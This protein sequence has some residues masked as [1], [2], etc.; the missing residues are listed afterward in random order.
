MIEISVDSTE[1]EN[2]VAA[3]QQFPEKLNEGLVEAV[4]EGED[5]GFL[6]LTEHPDPIPFPPSQVN[7]DS[8]TQR[9]AFHYTHG[10]GGGDPY[11]RQGA[12]ANA[13][14]ESTPEVTPELVSGK[15]FAIEDWVKYV[16]G[17][18]SQSDIHKGRWET[19]EQKASKIKPQFIEIVQR[20]VNRVIAEGLRGG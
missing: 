2:F 17:S 10:F 8:P 4:K 18:K 9:A 13:L 12:L 3:M 1:L 16:I 19:D 15:V 20:W 14:E 6:T 7:W 11:V 5:L